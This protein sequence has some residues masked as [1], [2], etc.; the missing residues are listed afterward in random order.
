MQREISNG[1]IDTA[2]DVVLT[3]IAFS[4]VILLLHIA[5][6]GFVIAAMIGWAWQ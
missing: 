2:E 4:T 6:L 3:L 1:R 5:Y